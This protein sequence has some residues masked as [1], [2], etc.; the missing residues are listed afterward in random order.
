M[1]VTQIVDADII[2]N[3]KFHYR[4]IL[5][6]R[7]LDASAGAVPFSWNILDAIIALKSAWNKVKAETVQDG[8]S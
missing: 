2:K 6:N 8:Y 3:L 4:Y 1:N 5:A 7:K